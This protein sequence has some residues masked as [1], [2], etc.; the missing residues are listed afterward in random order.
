[1][2]WVREVRDLSDRE[3]AAR[4]R[5]IWRPEGS[6]NQ[7]REVE[8]NPDLEFKGRE[9]RGV[10]E[11]IAN[12]HGWN[13]NEVI[14]SVDKGINLSGN[15]ENLVNL[16]EDLRGPLGNAWKRT[17]AERAPKGDFNAPKVSLKSLGLEGNSLKANIGETDYFTLWGIPGAAPEL[18]QKFLM[19]MSS[20]QATEVPSGIST[21]N[22]LLCEDGLVMVVRSRSQGFSAGHVSLSFEEQVE[23]ADETPFNTC[24]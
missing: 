12:P 13:R 20:T 5:F 19:E 17:E 4:E 24:L 15:P 23:P 11:I 6:S 8:Q 9:V 22:I 2:N 3:R 7:V 1:M 14:F 18:Q 16:S 10:I 21:H